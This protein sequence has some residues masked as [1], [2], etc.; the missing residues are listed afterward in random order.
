MRSK[1]LSRG[2]NALDFSPATQQHFVNM[3]WQAHFNSNLTGTQRTLR[4]TNFFFP[5]TL[6]RLLSLRKA[7][8]VIYGRTTL[9]H[10][11]VLKVFSLSLDC[12]VY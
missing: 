2:L 9:G 10:N 12:Q 3:L 8:R 6:T 1:E 11:C 7:I 4:P 5:R